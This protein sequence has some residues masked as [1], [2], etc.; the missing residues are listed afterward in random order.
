MAGR[1]V[2]VKA[3]AVALCATAAALA[4]AA[5]LLAVAAT[6]ACSHRSSDSLSLVDADSL[7]I[8]FAQLAQAYQ[9]AHPG[10]RV[11]T[12]SHGSIQVIRQVTDLGR[13]F[14][15]LTSADAGLVAAMMEGEGGGR[16]AGRSG[17]DASPASR[18]R[19]RLS[20]RARS[21]TSPLPPAGTPS[22]PPIAWSWPTRRTAATR[23]FSPRATGSA[24]SPRRACS[25]AWPTRASTPPATAPSWCCNLPSGSTTTTTSSPTSPS[26]AFRRRSP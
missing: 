2:A 20:R 12:E 17:A 23:R 10:V 19:G 11:E 15:V 5:L 6:S 25:S 13:S 9:S 7:I 8:P 4:V 21:A 22:L 16:V 18:R 14:D 24:R 1:R 26:A 3:A